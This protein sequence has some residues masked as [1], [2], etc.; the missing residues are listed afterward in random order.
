[1]WADWG[2]YQEATAAVGSAVARMMLLTTLASLLAFGHGLVALPPTVLVRNAGSGF[3]DRENLEDGE[4]TVKVYQHNS[5][6]ETNPRLGRQP[7]WNEA[8]VFDIQDPYQ[9]VIIQLVNAR[10]EQVLELS[11]DLNDAKLRDYSL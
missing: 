5:Y 7:I 1:M 3:V 11:L 8:I 4:H 2:F 10:Q 9:P 6:A